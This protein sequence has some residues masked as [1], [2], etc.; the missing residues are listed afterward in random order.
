MLTLVALSKM[1]QPICVSREEK[2][3]RHK[4][5]EELKVRANADELWP[6]LLLFPE[7]TCTNRQA[8]I[9]FKAGAFIPGKP[10]QPIVIRYPD[11]WVSMVQLTPRSRLLN[12]F[13]NYCSASYC[14]LYACVL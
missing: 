9:T 11:S 12:L 4:A 1:A 3:S 13:H 2:D 7:G 8:L 14:I 10:V 6:P 5:I